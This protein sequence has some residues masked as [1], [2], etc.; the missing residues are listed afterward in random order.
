MIS[1][2]INN[3]LE[4][5]A[6]SSGFTITRKK[7]PTTLIVRYEFG[8]DLLFKGSDYD[9]ITA[10]TGVTTDIIV[11]YNS[12]D[13][14]YPEVNGILEL[15]GQ[16]NPR[17]KRV[18]LP[19]ITED[20]Y[21]TII[22]AQE[23]EIDFIENTLA[24]YV[25]GVFQTSF[26]NSNVIY[27]RIRLVK[28]V[29]QYVINELDSSIIF[30]S[31]SFL[32]LENNT[33]YNN[34]AIASLSDIILSEEQQKSEAATVCKITWKKLYDYLREYHYLYWF[35]DSDKK[36][37]L[38][39][40][41]EIIKTSGEIDF[42]NYEGE[43]LTPL[44]YNYDTSN[45]YSIIKRTVADQYYDAA[46]NV[47]GT[48][49]EFPNIKR[50]NVLEIS[51]TSFFHSVNGTQLQPEDYPG[52]SIEDYVI[53]MPTTGDYFEAAGIS[54]NEITSFNNDVFCPTPV[55]EPFD[56]FSSSGNDIV[57][58]GIES[59]AEVSG[60]PGLG[61]SYYCTSN[62]MGVGTSFKRS[63]Y[64][65]S[66]DIA[67]FDDSDLQ[68]GDFELFISLGYCPGILGFSSFITLVND[69]TTLTLGSNELTFTEDE[70]TNLEGDMFL[71]SQ[72]I[73]MK[74]SARSNENIGSKLKFQLLNVELKPFTD[75]RYNTLGIPNYNALLANI[76]DFNKDLIE[77]SD[78][79]AIINDTTE[80]GLKVKKQKEV[81]ITANLDAIT[82]LDFDKTYNTDFGA[83]ELES[84]EY[85]I[86]NNNK[87]TI[88]GKF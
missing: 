28:D 33:I 71:S 26:T 40:Q 25:Y 53:L 51:F 49:I 68:L 31:D 18:E 37:R 1:V 79:T 78:S 27:N 15:K 56:I 72:N 80:T 42:T 77:F 54:D 44:T 19:V 76:D 57:K 75:F 84:V 47:R 22:E 14:K 10:L 7:D 45:I 46:G 64:K 36:F 55:T 29:I 23:N 73:R 85:Q 48:D 69:E 61:V 21:Q 74:I 65:L 32:F 2:K 8:G 13:A 50:E 16:Y 82:D 12:P 34:L 63:K 88:K 39:H 20:N 60:I 43:N 52:D 41:S 62:N 11:N 4:T 24:T 6:Y 35:I 58:I 66:F 67:I 87:F 86:D 38:K 81:E 59:I 17:Y 5:F 9:Y 70:F 83:I 3:D 30:D